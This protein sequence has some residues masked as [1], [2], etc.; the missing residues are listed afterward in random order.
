MESVPDPFIV[1]LDETNP[2]TGDVM[3]TTGGVRSMVTA[4]VAIGTEIPSAS[5]S[6]K[7]YAPSPWLTPEALRPSQGK[8][9]DIPA[10]EAER[11]TVPAELRM[12][13]IQRKSARTE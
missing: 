1:T 12:F 2:A 7:V 10:P 8:D 5:T 6:S 4:S 3:L 9:T 11:I 13:R